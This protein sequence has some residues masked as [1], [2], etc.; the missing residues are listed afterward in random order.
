MSIASLATHIR[1][2]SIFRLGE[3]NQIRTISM[4]KSRP[5]RAWRNHIDGPGISCRSV[6][7]G[8]H[9]F[10][11]HMNRSMPWSRPLI[12]RNLHGG[13]MTELIRWCVSISAAHVK[14]NEQ[15]WTTIMN[16]SQRSSSIYTYFLFCCFTKMHREFQI[17]PFLIY[18]RRWDITAST[19]L[20]Y[21]L[22]NVVLV[23]EKS[24]L[25]ALLARP[26]SLGYG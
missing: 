26:V 11:P 15:P 23:A 10:S 18:L 3:I 17:V 22:I 2:Q 7:I 9:Q 20:W 4:L 16:I 1:I 12:D 6:C 25:C 8:L 5:R 19:C 14:A 13:R 24:D 21:G